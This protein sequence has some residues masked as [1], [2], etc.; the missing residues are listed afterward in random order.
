MFAE[1]KSYILR[2]Q[3]LAIQRNFG[4]RVTTTTNKIL[5]EIIRLPASRHTSYRREVEGLLKK[6]IFQHFY[7]P[8]RKTRSR[9]P[10]F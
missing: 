8:T 4:T 3:S 9:V 5:R 2:N 6:R 10:R 7:T 1:Q